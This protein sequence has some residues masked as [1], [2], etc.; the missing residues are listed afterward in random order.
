MDSVLLLLERLEFGT[1]FPNEIKDCSSMSSFINE[2]TRR[3]VVFVSIAVIYM[4]RTFCNLRVT[5]YSFWMFSYCFF[6][7]ASCRLSCDISC[8][9]FSMYIRNSRTI[10]FLGTVSA[11][12]T[13]ITVD[14]YE[15]SYPVFS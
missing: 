10:C 9:P 14:L 5:F 4:C 1:I 11:L 2:L 7:R 8:C 6:T 13:I 3:L 12:Y 15:L